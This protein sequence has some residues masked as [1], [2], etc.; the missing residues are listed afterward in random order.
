MIPR[1]KLD[2]RLGLV[3]RVDSDLFNMIPLRLVPL[4]SSIRIR[5]PQIPLISSL[6]L[7][8]IPRLDLVLPKLLNLIPRVDKSPTSI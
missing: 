1:V 7:S 5:Q 8:L 3:P 4:V 2:P 6:S